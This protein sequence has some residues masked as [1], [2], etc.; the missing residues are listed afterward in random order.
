MVSKAAARTPRAA[1]PPGDA[2]A[3][4]GRLWP[5]AAALETRW[6]A[7]VG[8]RSRGRVSVASPADRS[9]RATARPSSR[10][11]AST[12][13]MRRGHS[14]DVAPALPPS[15]PNCAK[16]TAWSGHAARNTSI[17]LW[18]GGELEISRVGRTYQGL[19]GVIRLEQG[20]SGI[21]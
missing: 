3:A 7:P 8:N 12:Q 17:A 16:L 19:A 5:R 13:P 14:V 6:E 20:R 4:G 10:V 18:G 11:A 2:A 21:S 15:P 9:A 1:S